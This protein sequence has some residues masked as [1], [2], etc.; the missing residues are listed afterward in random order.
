[1]QASD[2]GRKGKLNVYSRSF[3]HAPIWA[4]I[5]TRD[6]TEVLNVSNVIF[7]SGGMLLSFV[8]TS[9]VVLIFYP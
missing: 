3:N 4:P 1:M 5:D 7:A 6:V 8:I 2:R 9:F